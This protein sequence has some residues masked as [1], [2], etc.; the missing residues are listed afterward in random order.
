MLAD[1]VEAASH[2]LARPT[3]A[4][5]EE[6]V[7]AVT[8][9]LIADGQ[10]D[11]SS[12]LI[13]DLTAIKES[14]VHLLCGIMHR[15]IEYPAMRQARR[16]EQTANLRYSTGGLIDSGIFER[17]PSLLRPLYRS[18]RAAAAT[19]E[20]RPDAEVS[21]LL[22]VDER[23]REL[24]RQFRGLDKST[25]VLSF[26]QDDPQLLGDIVVSIETAAR[27]ADAARWPL[28]S[29]LALLAVHGLLHL[30]GHD[31]ED[32]GDAQA[33][34]TLTREILADANV[35]LPGESHPFFCSLLEIP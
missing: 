16:L 35:A 26:A 13:R 32:L 15:R 20:L 21:L 19:L 23:I 11:E 5:I 14:F 27:Q 31:D 4:R 12:L 3:A 7:Q 34:E 17:I 8:D 1:S 18:L 6:L 2:T 28:E 29:E 25:D 33:M 10:L 24:N 22:T 9:G 30:V